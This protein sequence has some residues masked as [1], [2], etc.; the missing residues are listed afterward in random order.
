M[1]SKKRICGALMM[2]VLVTLLPS[3]VAAQAQSSATVAGVVRDTTGGNLPGVTVAASSPVLIEKVRIGVTDDRGQYQ[4]VNLVPGVYTITFTLPGFASLKR[5]SVALQAGF[6]ANVAVEMSVGS[7]E[8]S[9][10]VTGESPL[11]DTRSTSR[12]EAFT[13]DE[14]DALPT[15]KHFANL[16][17]LIPGM[18]VTSAVSSPN[19]QD[20][21]GTLG[22]RNPR[23]TF[24]GSRDSEQVS[25]F[26]GLQVTNAQGLGA[27]ANTLWVANSGIMDEVVIDTSGLS[28]EATSSGVR[29]NQIPRS[30]G[31]SMSGSFYYTYTND[32]LQA[33]NLDAELIARG[34][35]DYKT[36]K[37]WDF[38]PAVG[39]P[40]QKDRLWFYYAYRDWG[41]SDQPP[42]AFF[43]TNA[44]DWVYTPDA[45]RP[46]QAF[47]FF[48]S[49]AGRVTWQ[50]AQKHKVTFYTDT[51]S[52]CTCHNNV[53]SN[54]APEASGSRLTPVN[55]LL[56][57]N[58]TWTVSNKLL[59]EVGQNYKRDKW[60]YQ[61]TEQ[62]SQDLGIASAAPD[63]IAVVDSGRGITFRAQSGVELP[64]RQ[65]S[66]ARARRRIIR[67]GRTSIQ[68]WRPVALGELWP[69]QCQ[70]HCLYVR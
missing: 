9:I 41:S 14:I 5:D 15:A 23:L 18:R 43:D 35:T 65:H 61:R 56:Q 53:G 50:P 55:R 11:V 62:E 17:S 29:I 48:H 13:R 36:I 4:I 24:P 6:T 66:P 34:A 1:T 58:W 51:I 59:V 46:A 67:H 21:G 3:R 10:T 26:D 16:A 42:G 33:S 39:G 27:G 37:I 22:D 8:E 70:R 25:Q 64:V 54:Q 47:V 38:N 57:G 32:S 60:D 12:N 40:I 68:V 44:S 30:G 52:G 7:V 49:N 20:V 63:R 28:A 31:N 2:C 19:T 69:D 45:T